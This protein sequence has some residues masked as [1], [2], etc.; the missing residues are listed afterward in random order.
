[1]GDR[2]SYEPWRDAAG[3]PEVEVLVT[4]LPAGIRGIHARSPDGYRAILVNRDLPPVERLAALAHELVHD[5]RGGGCYQPDMPELM[6]PLVARDEA[7]TDQVAADRL[8]PLDRL[9]RWVALQEA[10]ERPVT[11]AW[12]AADLDVARWVAGD[13][14]RRLRALRGVA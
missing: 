12:A 4:R 9:E 13:Q 5:E 6:R 7:R 8:L 11:V 10:A 2:G 3:R 1:M 14:L